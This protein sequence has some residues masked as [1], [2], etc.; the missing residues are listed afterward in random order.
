[1]KWLLDRA[2]G[3]AYLVLVVAPLLWGG[4]AVA[5]RFAVGQWEPFTVTSVR[6]LCATVLLLPF[7]WG[8]LKKDW[9]VIKKNWLT[10]FL[11]GSVGMSGF[12]LLMYWALNYTTAINVSIEQASMPVLIMMANFFIMSQRVR[13]LQI[14]G[15]LLTLFGVLIATT[16]G[17]PLTFF[18]EGLNRGDAIMLFACVF[19]AGYTFGLR[20]RPDIHWLSFLIVIAAS[21]FV[22]TIPF[23]SWELSQKPFVLPGTNGWLVLL[24]VIIFPTFVSQ[25]CYARGVQLLGSNRAGLFLNLVPIFGS[26]LAVLIL[27][28]SFRWYHLLGLTMVLAGIGLAERAADKSS[29]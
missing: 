9:P 28:E 4:N 10:L 11:L 7:A 19:Y 29:P 22:M 17:E 24:Y 1:M 25:L 26:V 14:A 27:G 13:W 16:A 18:S 2:F 8:P 6:W 15:L 20:W 12:T 21:A 23:V 3:N 5:G